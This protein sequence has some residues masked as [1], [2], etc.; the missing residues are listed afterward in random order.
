MT[1]ARELAERIVALNYDALPPAAVYWSKVA[2]LDTMAVAL[3]GTV[4]A[5]PRIMEETL[6]L[7]ANSGPC[8]II[9]SN[10]R[11]ACLDATL[12]NATAAHALDYDN[13][14]NYIFGH[15]SAA[16][17]PALIAAGEEY[18]VS[19]QDFLL[20]FVAGYETTA[21]IGAAV[22]YY[23]SERGWHTTSTLGVFGVA[24]A[25]ARLLR[26]SVAETETALALSTSLA[27]GTRACFG[28]MAN[29]LHSAQCSR[30][31]LMA[32]LLARK[33]FT[34]NRQAFEHK[35]GFFNVFN[36]PG[37]YDASRALNCWG[38]PLHIVSPGASYKQYPCCYSTHA[39]V[40]AALALVR[41]HGTFDPR[42][43]ERVDIWSPPPR[44]THTSRPDPQTAHDAI[45]STEYC[46]ARALLKGRVV[47][48]DFE[49]DAFRDPVVRGLLQRIHATPYTGPLTWPDDPF[50]AEVKVT[51]TGG[52]TLSA[53]TD[54][55]L[56][57]TSDN[58][59]PLDNLKAKFRV[60]ARRALD[61]AAAAKVAG[62][63]DSFETLGSVREFTA[64]LEQPT[65]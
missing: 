41:E 2:L 39:A 22:T 1:L 19:G 31:G 45:F 12:V 48:E 63:I 56:G 6:G 58:P 59:I 33:G 57:R 15:E 16:M 44:L 47:L 8:L 65:R 64:L 11:V 49:G 54:R 46:V 55:P 50:D 53:H 30:G 52:K 14:S 3:A 18:G 4:E 34:A 37:T 13:T 25:C 26:L 40:D 35:Q 10:R 28:T 61:D 17:L 29:P 20:A 43:V 36:G 21:R 42:A 60:C 9:G 62:A 7:T 24:A 23:H 27:A 51:L 38:K 32:A 5:A